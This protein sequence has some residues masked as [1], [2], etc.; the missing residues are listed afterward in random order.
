[1][2]SRRIFL[3]DGG[4]AILG[5]SLVP[6]FVWR[7]AMAARPRLGPKKILVTIFQRG[8]V[9]G[10]NVVVPFGEKAYYAYRPSISVPAPSKERTSALDLDGFFGLH[11]SMA[12]LHPLYKGGELAIIHA[13]GSPHSTRSHFEAQ[14]YMETAVPGEKAARDG[15]LNRYLQQSSNAEATSFRG[16]AMGPVLPRALGGPAPALAL[17][18]LL[19]AGDELEE[20]E[21]MYRSMYDQESNT[22][23]S[24]SSREMFAAIKQLKMLGGQRYV[25]EKGVS[26][27]NGPFGQNL[28]QLAQL[29]KANVGVEVGFVDVGGWD[30]HNAQGG[31]E[32]TLPQRLGQF[33]QGI[34]AFRQ[35]LGGRMGDVVILTMSEFGR[36]ARENGNAGTD[37][38]KANVM[39]LLGGGVKGG[40]VYG[41]WPGLEREQLNEDRDLSLTTDFR[42]VFSEVLVRHL[43]CEDPNRV[44]P[45]FTVDQQRFRGVLG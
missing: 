20:T 40:K 26:Y 29:I 2:I 43:A 39:F 1:M 22:M 18:G 8:G 15:W 34:A 12:P 11:P 45:G 6:G 24:G 27:P 16:V 9:D 25:P 21:S 23:L 10:L 17:G 7:T 19:A 5:L 28:R 37:H 38:G 35:D 41:T 4:V 42:D 30:T 44:F 32:G 36:T 13:A 14:D 3:K 33:A 31:V